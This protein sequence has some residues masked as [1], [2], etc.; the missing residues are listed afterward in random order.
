MLGRFY[1]SMRFFLTRLQIITDLKQLWSGSNSNEMSREI[2]PHDTRRG[3]GVVW[4]GPLNDRFQRRGKAELTTE[5]L[6]ETDIR[7]QV[8]RDCLDTCC[9]SL[10]K[11]PRLETGHQHALDDLQALPIAQPHSNIVA[12]FYPHLPLA[13]C[14]Q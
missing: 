6:S 9:D 7:S 12:C 5:K 1:R 11:I 10:R 3:I 8:R 13:G 4:F 2:S 14:N